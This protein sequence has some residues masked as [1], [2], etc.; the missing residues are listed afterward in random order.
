MFSIFWHLLVL[1][2]YVKF[3]NENNVKGVIALIIAISMHYSALFTIIPIILYMLSFK[4]ERRNKI[5]ISIIVV[6][7]AVGVAAVSM[8]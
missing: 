4:K 1:L 8:P 5:V 7:S 3:S 6:G 2:A